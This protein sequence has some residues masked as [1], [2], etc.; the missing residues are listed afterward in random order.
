MPGN[1]MY[2]VMRLIDKLKNYW[3]WG[4]IAQTKYHLGLSD[5]Y[6]VE[7]KTLMEYNEYLM[8]SDALLRSD[9][10]FESIGIHIKSA[11]SEKKD[12]SSFKKMIEEAADKHN[13][14]IN[15]LLTIVP[16]QFTWTP[17]KDKPTDLKLKDLLKQSTAL[18]TRVAAD[19][20]SL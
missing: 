19:V 10:E 18:R 1:K 2:R 7:A 4:N 16:D 20:L 3:Y 5:K 6:L 9:K 15:S 8:A 11:K 12:I 13:Q 17:E 14:I